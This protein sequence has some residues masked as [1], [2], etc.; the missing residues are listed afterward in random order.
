MHGSVEFN[1]LSPKLMNDFIQQ[2]H[3]PNRT[4]TVHFVK[5]W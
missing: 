2:S 4:S 5:H 1:E 3:L